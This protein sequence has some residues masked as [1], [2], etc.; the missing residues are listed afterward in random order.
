[1]N[2]PSL[3]RENFKLGALQTRQGD[4]F[5][6]GISFEWSMGFIIQIFNYKL[7]TTEYYECCIK[8]TVPS[9]EEMNIICLKG[10]DSFICSNKAI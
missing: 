7:I 6:T 9:F 4:C 8:A 2:Y 5:C 10:R 3:K 1:M